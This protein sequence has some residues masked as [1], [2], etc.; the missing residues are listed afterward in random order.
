VLPQPRFKL[1]H[2][3]PRALGPHRP[4]ALGRRAVDLAL[5]RKQGIDAPHR[6]DRDRGF[7]QVSNLEELASRMDHPN[8]I[9]PIRFTAAVLFTG[10]AQA[11][12]RRPRLTP[13]S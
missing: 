11:S 6:L 13:L 9:A 12:P 5:D 8:T 4:S 10:T 1:G 3:R 2:K 7:L